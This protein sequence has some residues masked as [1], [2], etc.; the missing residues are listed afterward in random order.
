[1][2]TKRKLQAD[3]WGVTYRSAS[4]NVSRR[5]FFGWEAIAAVVIATVLLATLWLQVERPLDTP[6]QFGVL[7][8]RTAVVHVLGAAL[9]SCRS[10]LAASSPGPPTPFSN[11]L[12]LPL[13]LR[14]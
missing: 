7:S 2:T 4:R 13:G 3:W 1:M 6:P 14:V 8:N 10:K 12:T 5:I 9:F 11:H